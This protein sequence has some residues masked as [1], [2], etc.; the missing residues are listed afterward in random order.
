MKS[1]DIISALKADGWEQVAQKGSHV[2]FKHPTKKGRV[3]V[4]HPK[5][6]IPIGTLKSIEK[7]AAIKL[8]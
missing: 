2:Q 8:K 4:P 1:T 3:T 6:D 5:K 7:Q